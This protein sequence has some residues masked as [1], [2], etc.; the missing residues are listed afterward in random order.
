LTIIGLI[1][2]IPNK[3]GTEFRPIVQDAQEGNNPD[4]SQ[5][6]QN[7]FLSMQGIENLIRFSR[8]PNITIYPLAVYHSISEKN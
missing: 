5:A 6:F 3:D 8:Y 4:I 2:S 1:T 7:L